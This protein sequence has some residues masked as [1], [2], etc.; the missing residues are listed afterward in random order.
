MRIRD[1]DIIK[2]I[3][4]L[5][6]ISAA[7]YAHHFEVSIETAGQRLRRMAKAGIIIQER[8]TTKRDYLYLMPDI[9]QLDLSRPDQVFD[10]MIAYMNEVNHPALKSFNKSLGGTLERGG[11][12]IG[13]YKKVLKILS[14]MNQKGL[15]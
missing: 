7:D 1:N 6:A 3:K 10:S 13:A 4:E 15:I 12:H 5:G 8:G 9:V 11:G 2:L 14:E